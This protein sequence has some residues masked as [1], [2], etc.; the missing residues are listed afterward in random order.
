M[1]K[2]SFASGVL[3]REHFQHQHIA[4]FYLIFAAHHLAR[5]GDDKIVETESRHA[6]LVGPLAVLFTDSARHDAPRTPTPVRYMLAISVVN[7]LLMRGL[8]GR[9]MDPGRR[10]LLVHHSGGFIDMLFCYCIAW[11][12]YLLRMSS[13]VGD[14]MWF[15]F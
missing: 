1:C 3:G 8:R 7:N 15:V 12:S 13:R 10:A 9:D 6:W 2:D 11:S 5:S 14:F 4:R